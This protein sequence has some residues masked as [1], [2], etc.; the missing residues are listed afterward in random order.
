MEKYSFNNVEPVYKDRDIQ[1]DS[2]H[3]YMKMI[4]ELDRPIL[5]IDQE[6]ELFEKIYYGD[7]NARNILIESN[8]RLVIDVA[9]GLSNSFDELIDNIQNGNIGLIKSIDRYDPNRGVKFS[10]YAYYWIKKEIIYLG[11][12]EKKNYLRNQYCICESVYKIK[13]TH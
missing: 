5:T 11:Y 2:Y 9:K 13:T 8:L 7:Q 4:Y 6:K 10:T 12:K 3:K 1:F